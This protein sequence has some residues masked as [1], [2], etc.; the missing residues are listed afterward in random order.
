MM[1]KA[2]AKQSFTEAT[3]S[4]G[5]LWIESALQAI[6]KELK[7]HVESWFWE[8]DPVAG[9]DGIYSLIVVGSRRKRAGK[10][11]SKHEI[12]QCLSDRAVQQEVQVRLTKILTFLG[13]NH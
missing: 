12:E 1:A 10:L 9:A 6:G 7:V 8:N 5:M 3:V 4:P 13:P 2:A 11:F